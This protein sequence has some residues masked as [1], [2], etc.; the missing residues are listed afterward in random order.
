M[1]LQL[2]LPLPQLNYTVAEHWSQLLLMPDLVN[3]S[4]AL[5]INKWHG[6]KEKQTQNCVSLWHHSSL[7][8]G[9]FQPIAGELN[10]P[11]FFF[12]PSVFKVIS[13]EMDC[14]MEL[15]HC[16]QSSPWPQSDVEAKQY[17]CY[18]TLLIAQ[19]CLYQYWVNN[20]MCYHRDPF[21]TTHGGG[22]VSMKCIPFWS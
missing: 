11:P 17:P 4:A 2:N 1:N 3:F 13:I 9:W 14:E 21:K 5:W 18:V 15:G 12:Y 7:P 16:L 10:K 20:A 19:H 8:F 22:G 6:K